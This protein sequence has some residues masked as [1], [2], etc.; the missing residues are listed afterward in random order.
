MNR[1]SHINLN[2]SKVC[3]LN[4]IPL[5]RHYFSMFLKKLD[6]MALK[7]CGT[8]VELKGCSLTV[9]LMEGK[10]MQTKS[11]GKT[12]FK[13]YWNQYIEQSGAQRTIRNGFLLYLV[14]AMVALPSA[15]CSQ[16]QRLPILEI[17]AMGLSQSISA[18]ALLKSALQRL[19]YPTHQLGTGTD[20]SSSMGDEVE[21]LE[22]ESMPFSAHIKQAAETYSVDPALI[23][24]IIVA[25]SSYN[26]K[27]VSSRGARGL[28]QLMPATA[29]SLGLSDS[30]NP[31]SNID[32]GV[33]YFRILMDRFDGDVYLAL[34][35]YNAGSRY[36][37]Q[38]NGV[39]PFD[40]TRRYIKKVLHYQKKFQ[41]EMAA[42]EN[43]EPVG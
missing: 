38:Y 30:F 10:Y 6:N 43:S 7:G 22:K 29:R 5:C 36:V 40:A 31:A 4:F 26:P 35:A 9:E 24:A 16:Q 2:G 25:E 27:A 14:V 32:A 19:P 18:Q 23:R 28:M 13:M 34:A 33:R 37:R 12:F 3:D 41:N 39:P 15:L 11:E 1:N 8:V 20:T 17:S 21:A 42:G